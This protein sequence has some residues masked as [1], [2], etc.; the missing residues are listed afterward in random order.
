[1]IR[2]FPSNSSITIK[3]LNFLFCFFKLSKQQRTHGKISFADLA[4]QIGA[5]WNNLST[6]EKKKFSDS[7]AKEKLRYQEELRIWRL[8][9]KKVNQ[10]EGSEEQSQ[11]EELEDNSTDNIRSRVGKRFQERYQSHAHKIHD[12][13]RGLTINIVSKKPSPRL[14]LRS[15]RYR[16][17]HKLPTVKAREYDAICPLP[18]HFDPSH[19]LPSE[20]VNEHDMMKAV[21]PFLNQRPGEETY[22]D[23]HHEI[24]KLPHFEEKVSIPSI[25]STSSNVSSDSGNEMADI[26]T[27]FLKDGDV[28]KNK[29]SSTTTFN[30]TKLGPCAPYAI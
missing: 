23:E 8:K 13:P 28:D 17:M 7:A 22:C 15:R 20:I 27:F 26:L 5:A 25:E 19:C 30:N 11:N 9:K 4:K 10:D 21:S 24:E 29:T 2:C 18:L 3:Y 1:M 12:S 14:S 16:P 6:T